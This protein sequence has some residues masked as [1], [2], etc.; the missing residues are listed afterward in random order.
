[1]ERTQRLI[2]LALLIGWTIFRLVRYVRVANSKRPG[3]AVP[4]SAGA[5]PRPV[6]A[7]AAPAAPARAQS[8]IEPEGR[9][10]RRLA[11]LLAAAAV[12]VGGN[13]LIWAILFAV[14]AFDNVP[15][16]GRLTAGVLANLFLIRAA[17]A[18]A[19]TGSRSQGSP[20]DD[21]NPIK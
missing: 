21:R 18:V 4:P 12:F 1:M 20:G 3:P 15:T 8:P 17:G 9:R 7:P 10:G 13:V 6:P 14:P 5:L 11:G 16:I 2:F 19:R